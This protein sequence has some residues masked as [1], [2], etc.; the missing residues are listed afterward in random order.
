PREQNMTEDLELE[1]LADE[2]AQW[3]NDEDI[4]S[5]DFTPSSR[6]SSPKPE[7]GPAQ[8]T[9]G[10][11]ADHGN[12]SAAEELPRLRSGILQRELGHALDALRAFEND[13]IHFVGTSPKPRRLLIAHIKRKPSP[14][15]DRSLRARPTESE[16]NISAARC[17]RSG[18]HQPPLVR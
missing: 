15:D 11:P 12:R 5:F 8:P 17:R 13:Q 14:G 9:P 4:L 3:A 2:F 1:T 7:H 16:L 10:P 6:R 18:S